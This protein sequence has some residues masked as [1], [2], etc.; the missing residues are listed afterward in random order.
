M[1]DYDIRHGRTY[2]Y[3]HQKPLYAFGFGLSYTTFTYTNLR[4]SSTKMNDKGEV[5]VSVDVKNTGSRA[6]DEVI[7][8]YAAYPGSSVE[9]PLEELKGFARI[10]LKAGETK[11]VPLPLPAKSIAY[12]KDE[13]NSFVVE[14]GAIEVRIGSSSDNIRLRGTINISR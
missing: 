1:M 6:G 14:P 13:A 5:T 7:Q 2:L 4:F 10:F 8:L 9:R 11:T 3:L 12:W